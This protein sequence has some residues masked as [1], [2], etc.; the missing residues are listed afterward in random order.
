LIDSSH[1]SVGVVVTVIMQTIALII[2]GVKL[3]SR[4]SIIEKDMNSYS[5]DSRKL[6]I[7]EERQTHVIETL[8]DQ[9]RILRENQSKMD[10]LLRRGPQ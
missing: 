6:S 10:A 5:G 1:L 3:D 9:S 8:V 2:W 4:V 7:I